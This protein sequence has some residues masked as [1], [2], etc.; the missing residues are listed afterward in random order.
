MKKITFFVF[1]SLTVLATFSFASGETPIQVKEKPAFSYAYMSFSGSFK[2]M[3]QNIMAFMGEFFKQGLQPAGALISI[4]HNSPEMVEESELK[5][6]IGFPVSAGIQVKSPL[7]IATYEKKTVMV[8]TH[9]GSYDLL[10]AVYKKLT[11]YIQSNQYELVLPTYEFYLNNP[12][13]VKPE[14]LLTRIEIPVKKK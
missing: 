5:W 3:S 10:P 4:Y 9:Q 11:T 7:K 13:Q 6:D 2:T 8:F 12:M 14:E 1:L